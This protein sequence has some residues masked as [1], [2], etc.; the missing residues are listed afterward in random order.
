M[1]RW[2]DSFNATLMVL[3]F[4]VLPHLLKVKEKC[5]GEEGKVKNLEIICLK[6]NVKVLYLDSHIKN[7]FP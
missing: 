1:F 5:S 4:W 6:I 2:P 7:D 3:Y